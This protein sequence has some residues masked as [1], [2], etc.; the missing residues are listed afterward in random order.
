MDE[1]RTVA[2]LWPSGTE[3]DLGTDS[4]VLTLTPPDSANFSRIAAP[5]VT[6][7]DGTQ[8]YEFLFWNTGRHMTNKRKVIWIF[9]VFGWGIWTATRWYGTPPT[10][11]NGGH[12]RV[13]ADS[14]SI[15]GDGTLSPATPIDGAAS[16]YAAGAW[17]YSGDDHQ[18]DT[19]PGAA[20]VVAHDHSGAYDFGGWTELIW[21]GDPSGDFVETDTGT[22][23]SFGDSSFYTPV[24]AGT[25]P[26]HAAQN[27]THD[28]IASYV[29]EPL[30]QPPPLRA[31]RLGRAS[32][33]HLQDP[34]ERRPGSRRPDPDRSA[35]G[36]HP[37]GAAGCRRR[38]GLRAAGQGGTGDERRR[39][40]AVDPVGADHPRPRRVRALGD[41]CPAEPAGRLIV[42]R[43][44]RV[45]L[46][47]F[48]DQDNLGLRYLAS[49]LR[50][51]G[52]EIRIESFGAGA[53]PLLEVT[54]RWEPDVV[55]FSMIFQ[56]MAPDYAKVIDELRTAGVAAHFTMGGH[57]ASFAP[58]TLLELMPELDSVV[59]FEGESAIVELTDAVVA[60][61]P[62]REIRGLA[63]RDGDGTSTPT[64]P[65]E[66]KVDLDA[67]PWPERGDIAYDEQLLPTA[68]V[69]ASRGCPYKCSF[70]SIITFYAGNGTKG[71]R[72]RD[73]VAVVDEIEYLVRERGVRLILFQDD[74]FLAGGLDARDGRD[75]RTGDDRA[76]PERD[77]ALQVLLPVRR[78]A[79]GHPRAA[80]RGGPHARLPRRRGGRSRVA[81]DAQ[82]ADHA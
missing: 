63:W 52:H 29:P 71:R 31:H 81:E 75:R 9:S 44:A 41:V 59:R 53:G 78:G 36:A 23:G 11:T 10:V 35:R 20:T 18:I 39:A 19:V 56:F 3:L 24:T 50:A 62:W 43:P 7:A 21:G 33:R 30:R 4:N 48:Q 82:Q 77:D 69:L 72:R 5:F 54:Q 74:D 25:A 1:F 73:P 45:L 57:Y 32:R 76:R 8:N 66:D 26:F 22:T 60:G 51:A 46:V 2:R 37:E 13:R 58:E 55:G 65:R 42:L 14:F 12:P 67:I 17:P 34:P 38:H 61:G 15:N 49:S 6:S 47:G 79:T 68:S 27:S 64:P 40:E 28:L 70:C 16:T 80:D